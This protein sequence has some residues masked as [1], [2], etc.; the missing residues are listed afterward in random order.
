M[1][2]I[3]EEI[4]VTTPAAPSAPPEFSAARLHGEACFWCG[5]ALKALHPAGSVTTSV[6]GGVREWSV[7][8]CEE[9]RGR[10]AA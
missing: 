5:S 9:H 4:V 8:A 2:H 7:V 10:R 6:A 1:T 3:E